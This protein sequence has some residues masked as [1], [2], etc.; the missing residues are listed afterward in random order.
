MCA[1]ET[2]RGAAA[3]P[4]ASRGLDSPR[5]L[6]LRKRCNSEPADGSLAKR[7]NTGGGTPPTL[8]L[9]S[10]TPALV[11][12]PLISFLKPLVTNLV[13]ASRAVIPPWLI[14]LWVLGAAV[15]LISS[16]R[17]F[18]ANGLIMAL[19]MTVVELCFALWLRR[20]KRRLEGIRP[21]AER[22]PAPGGAMEVCKRTCDFIEESAAFTTT[23]AIGRNHMQWLEDWFLGTPFDAIRKD[24]MIEFC[25]WAFWTKMPKELD[26]ADQGIMDQVLEEFDRR[27]GF[28]F[29]EGHNPTVKPIRI[30]FDEL[31]STPF[32]FFYYAWIRVLHMAT[33]HTMRLLGFS[34]HAE[35][36][37]TPA[38]FHK[39]ALSHSGVLVLKGEE[40]KQL[41]ERPIVFFHGVGVGLSPYLPFLRRLAQ[42]RECFVIE[43]APIA[44]I[45]R[46]DVLSPEQMTTAVEK[47]LHEHGH[48][49]ACMVAH[50]F[51]TFVLSWLCRMNRELVAQAVFIDPVCIGL[52]HPDVAFNFLYK[53]PDDALML[54]AA[55]FVR[56]ELFTANVLYRHFSWYHNTLWPDELP[57][58]CVV[59]LSGSDTIVNARLVRLHLET[60]QR[61]QAQQTA[62][63]QPMCASGVRAKCLKLLWFEGFLHG[64]FLLDKPSQLQILSLLH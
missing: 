17:V 39:P 1:M 51:G 15:L 9:D 16:P 12:G 43:L 62:D 32:P 7:T 47:I 14:A 61:R 8:D 37:L 22:L 57:E 13:E 6:Q 23:H 50:S 54:V 44:Q 33:R 3:L 2:K 19:A 40:Q 25:A 36:G 52:S 64:F 28:R 21:L 53:E 55:H 29:A 45:C 10:I 4:V 20:T 49:S 31:Q 35:Q 30:S 38:Y 63:R 18:V 56:W 5:D 48:K 11:Y 41:P 60:H 26:E 27:F 59:A 34:Y 58:D 42:T 24:N 46:A